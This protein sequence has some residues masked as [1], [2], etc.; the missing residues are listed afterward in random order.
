MMDWL[1]DFIYQAN[2]QQFVTTS[3]LDKWYNE[4]Q[5]KYVQKKLKEL[6]SIPDFNIEAINVE[7]INEYSSQIIDKGYSLSFGKDTLRSKAL[8]I[9]YD[10]IFK[11][12]LIFGSLSELIETTT[13]LFPFEKKRYLNNL[14]NIYKQKFYS[15]GELVSK[16]NS[17]STQKRSKFHNEV[18]ESYEHK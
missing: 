12:L 16:S 10:P 7:D 5:N 2:L 11:T 17:P 4:K 14:K 6:E 15:V 8:S 9:T 13:G 1:K 3:Q 18:K